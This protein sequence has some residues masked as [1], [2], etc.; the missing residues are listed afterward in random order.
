[1]TMTLPSASTRHIPRAGDRV[2]GKY[3]LLAEIGSGGFGRVFAA[4]NENLQQPVAIKMLLEPG[5]SDHL[6]REAR[7]AARLRGPHCV[8]VFDVDRL[9][10]GS[11]YVVMELLAGM[12][13]KEYLHREGPIAPELAVR[14]ARQ[15]CSALREAHSAQLIHSDIKPSNVFVESVDGRA[16]VKLVDFGLAT[17]PAA[18]DD[19]SQASRGVVRGSPAYMSPEQVRGGAVSFASDIWSLGVVLYEMLSGRRPFGGKRS[20]ALFAAI[21]A[22]PPVALS[23]VAPNLPPPLV[24]IVHRC[25]RKAPNE[26]FG[27]VS[28]LD[29][30]LAQI[31]GDGGRTPTLDDRSPAADA[32]QSRTLA[33]R[34]G[35]RAPAGAKST[36][37]AGPSQYG[38]RA[39]GEELPSIPPLVAPT[40]A[41]WRRADVS[42]AQ[43][44]LIVVALVAAAGVVAS[45]RA[46]PEPPEA[47]PS[48]PKPTAAR[49]ATPSS[50]GKA[51]EPVHSK[52]ATTNDVA[53]RSAAPPVTTTL[54]GSSPTA[55]PTSTREALAD[56]AQPRRLAKPTR[57]STPPARERRGVPP[58]EGELRS[59]RRTAVEPVQNT[60]AGVATSSAERAP[61]SQAGEPRHET[62]PPALFA[63]PDF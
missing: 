33:P 63:E 27:S 21:A 36:V 32:T 26:R 12:S 2:G 23:A 62:P 60:P 19:D 42:F 59:D 51:S 16:R 28:E 10:C 29:V 46:W 5:P 61:G 13:L 1:M 34:P 24:D 43:R 35:G 4:E 31:G 50:L 11:P 53:G 14:W 7:A 37:S 3:R 39:A 58:V 40:N 22:D 18:S 44:S 6:W 55:P 47:T 56:M 57:A 48:S 54:P 9:S 49:T 45:L 15:L 20:T 52:L 25:L 8:R 41:R 38:K 17:K 30:A